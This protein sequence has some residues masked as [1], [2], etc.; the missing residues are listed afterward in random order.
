MADNPD[1]SELLD[2][3]GDGTLSAEEA[4]RLLAR[5][6]QSEELRE[7]LAGVAVAQRLLTAVHAE[8][9]AYERVRRALRARGLM[10]EQP[11]AAPQQ[12]VKAPAGRRLAMAP[13]SWNQAKTSAPSSPWLVVG[14]SLTLG[15]L[16]AG[17]VWWRWRLTVDTQPAPA[18]SSS[19]QQSGRLETTVTPT[20]VASATGS[21]PSTAL[22]SQNPAPTSPPEELGPPIELPLSAFE[23]GDSPAPAGDGS[24]EPG[25][26]PPLENQAAP[27]SGSARGNDAPTAEA[28]SNR[29]AETHPRDLPSTPLLVVELKMDHPGPRDMAADDL[30]SLLAEMRTRLGLAYRMEIQAL[31]DID[32]RPEKNPILYATGHYHFAFTP[33][34]RAKLRKFLLAGGLLVFDAGLGSKPFYDSARRELGIIFRDVRLQRLSSDHPLFRSCYDLAHV[35]YG[36]GV[37][38]HGY[39]GD[40]P[41]FEGVTVNC[42]TLAIVSRWGLAGGWA[43]RVQDGY[44]A[45]VT[46]DAVK[47]G[48]NLCSYALAM[49][50]GNPQAVLR[51]ASRDRETFADKLFLGQV[52]YDG[53]WKT[54]PAAL[55]V[56]LRT[57]NRRT[58]VPVK[59]GIREL[60]LSDPKIFDA[61]LLYIT[62]H[63]NFS[64]TPEETSQLRKYLL[65]GGFLFAEACCGRRGF[66]QAFRATLKKVFPERDLTPIP[67]TQDVF[68]APNAIQQISLTPSL[69]SQLGTTI[70]APKLEG[71]ELSGHYAVIYS[72]YGIAGCWDMFQ[73]PYALGY[74]D[75][76]ALKLG[77][78]IL[79]Y[80]I[81]H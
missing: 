28:G 47:L 62:G 22:A 55:L 46:E 49:H 2:S 51:G 9:V 65:S 1:I 50:G 40:E 74:N 42:R 56:L 6:E 41:W 81:T 48:L 52:V 25:F 29:L 27:A 5:L 35:R 17:G 60:R 63:E 38:A 44:P 36:A 23:D 31:D 4:Q 20:Q 45:Y 71:L 54:K 16:V 30:H 78:N 10:P 21:V 43:K 75:I 59:L 19:T 33:A 14:I 34:Q 12:P 67:L 13:A 24:Q 70:M 69:A 73:S 37:P 61:P 68:T 3:Y 64:L 66:D 15:L 77:Q 80:A 58:E 72:P 11:E 76:E 39:T 79:F 7:Q 53:E 57:F 18:G 8:P 32:A 26:V